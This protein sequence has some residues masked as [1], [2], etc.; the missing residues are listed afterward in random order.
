MK[1]LPI[2]LRLTLVFSLMV[3]MLLAVTAIG[4]RR[5]NSASAMTDQMLRARVPDE[6]IVDEWFKVLEVNPA[7][8]TTAWQATDPERQQ[9]VEATMKKSSARA[10]EIQKTLAKTIADPGAKAA[11][12]QVLE[13]RQAYTAARASVFK[14]KAAANIEAARAIFDKQLTVRREAYLGSLAKLSQVQPALLDRTG[15]EIAD[16]YH[17]GKRMMLALGALSVVLAAVSA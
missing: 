7:R 2:E 14:E 12:A 1:N 11:L 13:A 15:T 17:G 6:R 10:T 8:T 16:N 3:A 5:M 4:V 9:E